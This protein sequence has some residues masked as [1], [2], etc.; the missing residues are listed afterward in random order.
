MKEN[1]ILHAQLEDTQT[2]L[3]LNKNLLFN[4]IT[5]MDPIIINELKIENKRLTEH[6]EKLYQDR[7]DLE[8]KVKFL[9]PVV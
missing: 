4:H 9:N 7:L 8:K 3:K 6:V 1:N 2:T 5:D